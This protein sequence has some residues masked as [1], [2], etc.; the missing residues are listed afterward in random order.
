MNNYSQAHSSA[1][2]ATPLPAPPTKMPAAKPRLLKPHLLKWLQ[3]PQQ[4][5]DYLITSY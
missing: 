4:L 5:R 2:Q 1:S 3:H